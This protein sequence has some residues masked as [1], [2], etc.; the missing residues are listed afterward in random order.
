MSVL[1]TCLFMLLT[2]PPEACYKE[3]L[4]TVH[5]KRKWKEGLSLLGSW[6]RKRWSKNLCGR[7]YMWEQVYESMF[8]PLQ[9][10]SLLL[11]SQMKM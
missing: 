7:K 10:L 4:K 6:T 8:P 9:P 5:V 1:Y 11:P 2:W 3:S